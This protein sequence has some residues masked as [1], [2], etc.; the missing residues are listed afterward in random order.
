MAFDR[1]NDAMA[2]VQFYNV[3]VEIPRSLHW[4]SDDLKELF[5]GLRMIN[6]VLTQHL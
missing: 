4:I 2:G 3:G 6:G 5:G 1:I